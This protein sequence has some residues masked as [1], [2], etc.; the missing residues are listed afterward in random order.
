[1]VLALQGAGLPKPPFGFPHLPFA[2][3]LFLLEAPRLP[4]RRLFENEAVTWVANLS[5]GIYIWHSLIIDL[6]QRAVP[7]SVEAHSRVFLICAT[8]LIATLAIAFM[9]YRHFE[10]P[11]MQWA[12]TLERRPVRQIAGPDLSGTLQ[13][14]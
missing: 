3:A 11:I 14:S 13:A 4:L 7:G 5:F 1:M 10:L 6:L 9:S 8:D 2:V 12:K